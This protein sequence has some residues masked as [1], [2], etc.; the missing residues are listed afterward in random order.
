MSQDDNGFYKPIVDE[1]NCIECGICLQVCAFN[2]STPSQEKGFKHQSFAAWSKN[3][4]TRRICTSGGVSFEIGCYLI[5]KGYKAIVCKYNPDTQCAEHYVAETKEELEA[6]I[7]SKYIQSHAADA[8]SQ[9]KK[10]EKYFITGCPCQIDSIR[11]WLKR[12]K[13]EDDVIFLDFFCHGVPSMLLWKQ[14]LKETEEKIGKIGN[15][16]WRDKETGWHDS[17]VMK[18]KERYSSW[19]SKG[20]LFYRMFLG[21]RCLGKQCYK[22]CKYK[23]DNSAADIRIGD[24]WGRKYAH[25]EE[26]VNGVLCLT[27]KGLDLLQ[28][29]KDVLHIESSTLEIIGEAQMK[30]CAHRPLSYPSVM[31][32]LKEGKKLSEIQQKAVRIELLENI[33]KAIKYYIVRFPS[34]FLEIIGLK[35]RPQV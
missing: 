23:Y 16:V 28:E 4:T 13:M 15:I 12:R 30:K 1:R 29:M 35:E 8:L 34:K 7:G 27:Q 5:N 14:Y 17:W 22:D 18:V 32:G 6:S 25:D 31:K 2:A 33:P 20:D 11:R 10:G 21:D 26:G 24:L 9:I 19:F 3:K